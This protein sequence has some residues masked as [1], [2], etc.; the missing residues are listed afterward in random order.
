MLKEVLRHDG[1]ALRFILASEKSG[2]CVRTTATKFCSRRISF[3]PFVSTAY[4]SKLSVNRAKS[5]SLSRVTSPNLHLCF[6]SHPL[7]S[8]PDLDRFDG[9]SINSCW[10][11]ITALHLN[12]PGLN[13]WVYHCCRTSCRSPQGVWTFEQRTKTIKVTIVHTEPMTMLSS[14]VCAAGSTFKQRVQI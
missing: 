8:S 10:P 9:S 1:R 4:R 14:K 13:R 11:A 5:G 12:D 7:S 6:E 3:S 2:G